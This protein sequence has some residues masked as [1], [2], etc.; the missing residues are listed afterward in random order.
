MY[1]LVD[2]VA[3]CLGFVPFLSLVAIALFVFWILCKMIP[4]LGDWM[5]AADMEDET[6]QERT[7][8]NLAA[9]TTF[10]RYV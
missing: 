5:S 4:S 10:N 6:E 9:S 2:F 1:T 3:Y 7:E 8:R